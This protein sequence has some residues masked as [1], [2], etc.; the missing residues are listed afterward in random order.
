ME[1]RVMGIEVRTK[2]RDRWLMGTAK[3]ED[4][5]CVDMDVDVSLEEDEEV[6][7]S[8]TGRALDRKSIS[9]RFNTQKDLA[10]F[11]YFCESLQNAFSG[12]VSKAFALV[13]VA[14]RAQAN[15]LPM[16]RCIK[17][18]MLLLFVTERYS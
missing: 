4:N 1:V 18:L 12:W 13:K 11:I 6:S 10:S 17:S 16:L 15:Y 14:G 7:D 8:A 5:I 9:Y 2:W 3:E